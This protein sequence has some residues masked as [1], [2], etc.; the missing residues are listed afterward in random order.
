MPHDRAC[1]TP[2]GTMRVAST[3]VC[4]CAEPRAS[5]SATGTRTAPR[6]RGTHGWDSILHPWTA[7]IAGLAPASAGATCRR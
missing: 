2:V 6:T 1:R 4:Q 3:D 7:P 5:A